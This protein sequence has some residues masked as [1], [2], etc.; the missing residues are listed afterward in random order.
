MGPINETL[1]TQNIAL[2]GVQNNITP[3]TSD[4]LIFTNVSGKDS[5]VILIPIHGA[6]IWPNLVNKFGG[7]QQS[8]VMDTFCP[9][10][11]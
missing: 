4:L 6:I 3:I 8:F 11:K 1:P 7:F 2:S 10:S 5:N 9:K